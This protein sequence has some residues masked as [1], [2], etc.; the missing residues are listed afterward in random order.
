M[1]ASVI[2][3]EARTPAEIAAI[4]QR[5]TGAQLLRTQKKLRKLRKFLHPTV[6]RVMVNR[7]DGVCDQCKDDVYASTGFCLVYPN[8]GTRVVHPR[9]F[10]ANQASR[11]LPVQARRKRPAP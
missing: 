11:L 2:A 9:C 3:P 7:F 1:G 10:E 8:A 4:R 6:K 5:N